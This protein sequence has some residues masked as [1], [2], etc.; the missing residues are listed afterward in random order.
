[1]TK[2][3]EKTSIFFGSNYFSTYLSAGRLQ[4]WKPRRK[5]LDK[6]PTDFRSTSKKEKYIENIIKKYS[7]EKAFFG[8]ED[9]VLATLNRKIY[10]KR[11]I[12]SLNVRKGN[13]T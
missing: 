12:F 8:G 7:L 5:N 3:D 13:S 4:F 10:L 11:K 1:M 6:K 9:S 2:N